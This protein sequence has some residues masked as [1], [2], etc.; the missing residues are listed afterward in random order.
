MISQLDI[1]IRSQPKSSS[2]QLVAIA[3][4]HRLHI[5]CLQLFLTILQV[6]GERSEEES[7]VSPSSSSSTVSSPP[8]IDE[9]RKIRRLAEI[10]AKM[11]RHVTSPLVRIRPSENRRSRRGHPA[12]RPPSPQLFDIDEEDC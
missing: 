6:I 10:E 1:A 9:S 3:L 2:P 12:S 4:M 7:T 11:L 8:S 5:L